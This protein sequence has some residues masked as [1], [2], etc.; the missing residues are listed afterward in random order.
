MATFTFDE[1]T[2]VVTVE[3][4]ALTVTIQDLHDACRDYEAYSRNMDD[5]IL[6]SAGGKEPLGGGNSVAITLRLLNGWQ[7]AF[8]ARGGPA[9]VSC[10]I[11]GGNLVRLDPVTGTATSS[12][13]GTTLIDSNA[14]FDVD[15]ILPG[16]TV[17]NS[18][19]GSSAT[20]ISVDSSTQITITA[21]SGGTE[22]DWDIGEA[23]EITATNPIAPTAFTQVTYAQSTAP[24]SIAGAT[25]EFVTA[26]SESTYDG[27]SFEDIMRDLLAMANARIVE[28]PDGVFTFYDRDN[29]TVRYTLTKAGNERTRS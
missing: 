1:A 2:K 4:P 29:T 12:D 3:A 20:V 13:A 17:V 21:L 26:L 15:G 6:V 14:S 19:D 28:S 18:D 24:V 23:Y 5:R 10:R 22:N 8:A 7:V 27:V 16:D 9:Y 11:D 25:S